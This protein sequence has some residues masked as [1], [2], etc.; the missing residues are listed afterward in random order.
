MSKR[1]SLFDRLISAL[2]LDVHEREGNYSTLDLEAMEVI[3]AIE[4]GIHLDRKLLSG[5]AAANLLCEFPRKYIGDSNVLPMVDEDSRSE[6]ARQK[7]LTSNARM[8]SVNNRFALH[9]SGTAGVFKHSTL[10]VLD[11]AKGLLNTWLAGNNPDF[12][13]QLLKSMTQGLITGPGVSYGVE[14]DAKQSFYRKV[15]DSDLHFSTSWGRELYLSLIQCDRNW[16]DAENIRSQAYSTVIGEIPVFSDVPKNREI[17]RPILPSL[18]G[19]MVL[20]RA[21]CQPLDSALAKVPG[22]IF[23]NAQQDRNREMARIAS[24]SGSGRHA[25]GTMDLS[26]ASNSV[27]IGLVRYLLPQ[28]FTWLLEVTTNRK[29][30]YSGETL[31]LHMISM[32]GNGYTFH[33]E[34]LLFTSL[35]ISCFN[36]LGE[37]P[38]KNSGVS[39][40]RF[41]VYGDDIIAPNTVLSLLEEVLS[42]LGFLVNDEKTYVDGNF[43]ESCGTDWFL[44]YDIR[45]VYVTELVTP[46]EKVS[47]LNRLNDWSCR[48]GIPLP[49]T[50]AVLWD[51][52]PPTWRLP[53][54]NWEQDDCGIKV[55]EAALYCADLF[56]LSGTVVNPD[57]WAWNPTYVSETLRVKYGVM[58]GSYLYKAMRPKVNYYT[59]WTERVDK[60]FWLIASRRPMTRTTLANFSNINW[61]GALLT[62]LQ[63]SLRNGRIGIPNGNKPTYKDDFM[64][65]PG[66]GDPSLAAGNVTE[67]SQVLAA[68]ARW[69]TCIATNLSKI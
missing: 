39:R 7:F 1:P 44:G 52:I 8:E 42:D 51:S 62:A 19:D 25:F 53:V 54:P 31:D 15:C 13:M 48:H 12:Y 35:V 56:D 36:L 61:P 41:A 32:M 30:V 22:G 26:D 29:A 37:S 43:R 5:V 33:L 55:P 63:G 17:K 28:A 69:E 46:A 27:S 18:N 58:E 60:K 38:L 65:A 45:G 11:E 47:L 66:W 64:V 34:T 23:I 49:R 6:R 4:L 2:K 16:S 40:Q 21:L 14:G 24:L 50:I 59:L 3:P 20:Q 10:Y 68:Y 67:R 9:A 57:M